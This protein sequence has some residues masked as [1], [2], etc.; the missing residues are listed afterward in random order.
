MSLTSYRAAPPRVKWY[1]CS[2]VEL[3]LQ[4]EIK[5]TLELLLA[6]RLLQML[7]ILSL[8]YLEAV[9][10]LNQEAEENPVLEVERQDEY[11]EFLNYLTSDKKVRKEVDFQELPGLA[12]ISR[13]EKTLEQHLLDQLDLADLEEE[14]KAI[15]REMIGNIDDN[16]YLLA[17]PA[18][19]D[20]LMQTHNVSRPTVDKVLKI[21]QGFEPEGVG[22]RDLKECLLIQIE[23]YSFENEELETL[24]TKVVKHHLEDLQANDQPKVAE[25]LGIPESGVAEIANFLKNNLSPYPG[26]EFGGETRQIIPSFAVEKSGQGFKVINL[27]SRYGPTLNLSPHYLKM[28]TDPKTDAA[29]KEYLQ[30][31]VKRAKEL[32]EDFQKRSETLEKIARKIIDSQPEFLAKGVIWLKPLTQKSLA[33]EFGLHPSTISRT[34]AEK[35]VQTE[36]GLFPLRLLCP[37][38]PKGV[39]AA[40]LK[41]MLRELIDLEDKHNPLSD[42]KLT[43]LMK[44]Q[45]ADIDRRTVAYYRKELKL[46]TAAE[47]QK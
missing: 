9:E 14:H 19:R 18:L 42:E 20:R 31:K 27:E 12:N 7:K 39:T 38:G 8:P 47:R 46:P 17:Y 4:A 35:Y 13:Q 10:Q 43:V 34:V 45:G 36:H 16:G 21:I 3:R 23:A 6:P 40:R 22:A 37:R 28:L 29:T 1:N 2:M 44:K 5:Q 30:A 41:A 25:S 33:D 32:I 24:L 26:T 11:I 15:A